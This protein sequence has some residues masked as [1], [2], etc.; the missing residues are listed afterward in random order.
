MPL[1][2]E[3]VLGPGVYAGFAPPAVAGRS[4][5]TTHPSQW[6]RPKGWA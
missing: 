2:R 4:A 6:T 3:A 1:F 5:D